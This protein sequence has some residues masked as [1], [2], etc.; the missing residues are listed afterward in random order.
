MMHF[1]ELRFFL[2]TV[3]L[4]VLSSVPC[5]LSLVHVDVLH[6]LSFLCCS[7]FLLLSLDVPLLHFIF[8]YS[9]VVVGLFPETGDFFYVFIF[10][11][12]IYRVPVPSLHVSISHAS[13]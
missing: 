8:Y 9:A 2:L 10:F 13:G 5:S 12:S 11:M 1:L 4:A 7:L 6:V 3:L